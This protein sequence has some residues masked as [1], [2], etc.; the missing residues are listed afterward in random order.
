MQ[1]KR[2]LLTQ[3]SRIVVVE[4]APSASSAGGC[5]LLAFQP[6]DA[7]FVMLNDLEKGSAGIP[8]RADLPGMLVDLPGV[9]V[10]LPG[11]FLAFA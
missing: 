4:R 10:D 1:G 3:F 9:F 6:G 5:L 11:L 2:D 8:Q 7:V